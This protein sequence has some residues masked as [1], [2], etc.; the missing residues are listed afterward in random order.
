MW[1]AERNVAM[2]Q[3][4]SKSDTSVFGKAI[5][6]L[7]A[8]HPLIFCEVGNIIAEL[9]EQLNISVTQFADV[10][11]LNYEINPVRWHSA[12]QQLLNQVVAYLL[13][14]YVEPTEII[15]ERL[16]SDDFKTID[17]FFERDGHLA[18]NSPEGEKIVEQT[19]A[20]T[21]TP[22]MDALRRENNR[23]KLEVETLHRQKAR[24]EEKAI[25]ALRYR[26]SSRT[27]PRYSSIDAMISDMI[28]EEVEEVLA[29][30]KANV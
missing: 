24:A 6:E 17:A 18:Q 7:E 14:R 8:Q 27:Q 26:P 9:D 23:L 30:G 15:P 11:D 22:E 3:A 19:P 21:I 4:L 10:F 13:Q 28:R 5:T 16:V 25:S 12:R 2:F 29:E 1:G 20:L